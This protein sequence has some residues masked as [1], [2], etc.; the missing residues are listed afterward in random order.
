M[1]TVGNMKIGCFERLKCDSIRGLIVV[2]RFTN[3]ANKSFENIL[4][5]YILEESNACPCLDSGGEASDSRR[6]GPPSILAQ[7]GQDLL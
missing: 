7:L 2:N 1:E 4:N 6:G 3:V 5:L